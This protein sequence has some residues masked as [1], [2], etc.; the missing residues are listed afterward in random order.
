MAL[1]RENIRKTPDIWKMKKKEQQMEN[2][3]LF[4]RK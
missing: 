3:I 4:E 2:D 1:R